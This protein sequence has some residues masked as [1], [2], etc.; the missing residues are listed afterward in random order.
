[1]N[2]VAARRPVA[3][4]LIPRVSLP[5]VLGIALAGLIATSVSFGDAPSLDSAS[6]V[7]AAPTAAAQPQ[8]RI[9]KHAHRATP[10]LVMAPAKG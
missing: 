7:A 1:M 9:V 3:P 8:V 4:M 5:A 10:V 6:E 2:A